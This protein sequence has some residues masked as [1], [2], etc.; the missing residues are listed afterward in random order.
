[1]QIALFYLFFPSQSTL[2]EFDILEH[3]LTHQLTLFYM[4][5]PSEV[6]QSAQGSKVMNNRQ[7]SILNRPRIMG[8]RADH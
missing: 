3:L 1:M 8:L 4:N 7:D 5:W 6:L 2:S